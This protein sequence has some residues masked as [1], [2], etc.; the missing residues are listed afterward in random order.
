[1]RSLHFHRAVKSHSR[2]TD[3]NGSLTTYFLYL[4]HFLLVGKV[5]VNADHDG[6]FRPRVTELITGSV[7][8]KYLKKHSD[9]TKRQIQSVAAV[10]ESQDLEIYNQH[11][12]V[13]CQMASRDGQDGVGSDTWSGASQPQTTSTDLHASL[14]TRAVGNNCKSQSTVLLLVKYA[15]LGLTAVPRVSGQRFYNTMS[16]QIQVYQKVQVAENCEM[17]TVNIWENRKVSQ[18]NGNNPARR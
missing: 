2:T 4:C 14:M 8:H 9:T 13:A 17:I 12:K 16:E 11:F 5:D 1:M 6:S 10:S 18:K 15:Y 3:G 7:F